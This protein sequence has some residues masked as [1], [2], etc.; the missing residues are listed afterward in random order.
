[1]HSLR[2]Q[3]DKLRYTLGMRRQLETQQNLDIVQAEAA[4]ILTGADGVRG[5][6]CAYGQRYDAPAVVVCSGVYLNS[7]TFVGEC[8]AQTGPNGLVRSTHLTD[9]LADMGIPLRRF[10]TRNAP[11][12]GQRQH[13][14]FQN[15]PAGRR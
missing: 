12:G 14:F 13:R 11:A 9:S 4:R 15:A 2:A 7:R 1:M 8:I 10:K 3:V 6:E 5:V